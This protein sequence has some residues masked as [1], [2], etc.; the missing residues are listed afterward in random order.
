MRRTKTAEYVKNIAIF[1]SGTGSNARKIVAH[2]KENPKI[3]VKL[4]VSN[5]ADAP[6]LNMAAENGISTL[7]LSRKTFYE[8]EQIL[9]AL[10]QH[11]IDL[12]ALA[13]FLWLV[14]PYLVKAYS[15]RM[16]NIHP[17][18]LPAFGGKGMYGMNVHQAVKQAG[19]TESGM[20]IHLVNEAYDSGSVLLQA[21]CA[22]APQDAPEDIA[23]KV[24]ALEHQHYAPLLEQVLTNIPKLHS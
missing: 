4:L 9:T 19:V 2:F 18:L 7:V 5:R 22:I 3:G 14:P 21:T 17:A 10:Q 16:V 6:V 12:I 8:S 11:D 13:G 20:T 15:G 24:L 1:A 23:R